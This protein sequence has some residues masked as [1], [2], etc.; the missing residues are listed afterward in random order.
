MA[1]INDCPFDRQVRKG[2]RGREKKEKGKRKRKERTTRVQGETSFAFTGVQQLTCQ[3]ATELSSWVVNLCR[4][5]SNPG[6]LASHDENSGGREREGE[7]VRKRGAWLPRKGSMLLE[8][9]AGI[10]FGCAGYRS[11]VLPRRRRDTGTARGANKGE[12]GSSSRSR[13]PPWHVKEYLSKKRERQTDRLGNFV[14]LEESSVMAEPVGW[15]ASSK[16]VLKCEIMAELEIAKQGNL[17]SAALLRRAQTLGKLVP[18]MKHALET[19]KADVL[20]RF[21]IDMQDVS[22]RLL[23]LKQIFPY[24]NVSF[25]VTRNLFLLTEDFDVVVVSTR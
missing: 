15:T 8:K 6:N 14:L 11:C 1:F 24:M 3:I 25:V 20:C 18:D 23:K 9:A 21:L 13:A 5:I 7:K 10:G 22:E 19:M 16:L 4:K 17:D 12:V 2:E